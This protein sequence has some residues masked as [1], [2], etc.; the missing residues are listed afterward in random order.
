MQSLLETASAAVDMFSWTKAN[1]V[2][3]DINE[4]Q[5][6]RLMNT[7]SMFASELD[8][9]VTTAASLSWMTPCISIIRWIVIFMVSR[10]F[11]VGYLLV[12]QSQN[13]SFSI[14]QFLYV[15]TANYVGVLRVKRCWH[16]FVWSCCFIAALFVRLAWKPFLFHP[17]WTLGLNRIWGATY[18][19]L[20]VLL[21][22]QSQ[23]SP[24]KP[25]YSFSTLLYQFFGIGISRNVWW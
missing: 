4:R 11:I 2:Q 12:V 15:W 25:S 6:Q 9:K 1:N 5:Y 23:N 10:L 24:K 13:L 7:C 22:A 20:A 19:S 14:N 16:S 3:R 8:S 17:S 21:P 18:Y